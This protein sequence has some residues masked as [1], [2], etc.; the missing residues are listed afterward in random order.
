MISEHDLARTEALAHA[1]GIDLLGIEPYD[2]AVW[3]SLSAGCHCARRA[4][5]VAQALKARAVLRALA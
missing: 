2:L 1:D 5:E 4:P 3:I